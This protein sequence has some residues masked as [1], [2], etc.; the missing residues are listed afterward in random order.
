M[1]RP[2]TDGQQARSPVFV[3]QQRRVREFIADQCRLATI[4]ADW[5]YRIGAEDARVRLHQHGFTP[6]RATSFAQVGI[7][8]T[9]DCRGH[10]VGA[11]RTVGTY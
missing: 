11:P 2:Q 9:P 3:T 1:A 7:F 10:R 5:L 4:K 6:I 8:A